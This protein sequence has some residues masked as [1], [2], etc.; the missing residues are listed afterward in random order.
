MVDF[1]LELHHR[2]NPHGNGVKLS[3]PFHRQGNW[4][5]RRLAL[6]HCNPSGV[7]PGLWQPLPG[8]TSLLPKPLWLFPGGVPVTE[9][10]DTQAACASSL[11]PFLRGWD[12]PCF[13]PN[14]E[15]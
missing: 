9:P 8:P 11:R 6:G 12:P 4:E 3:P 5:V 15:H 2:V 14:P 10:C 13:I 7:L 1:G